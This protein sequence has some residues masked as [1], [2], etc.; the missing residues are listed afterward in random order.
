MK[1]RLF[2]VALVLCGVCFVFYWFVTPEGPHALLYSGFGAL[3]V[4]LTAGFFL[5][6][7]VI[8]WRKGK[9]YKGAD[10][11]C[12]PAECKEEQRELRH[13]AV[14]FLLMAVFTAR[15]AVQQVS[16][17][18]LDFSQG[19]RQGILTNAYAYTHIRIRGFPHYK[20]FGMA[21]QEPVEFSVGRET[22]TKVRSGKKEEYCIT[23]YEHTGSLVKI[24]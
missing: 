16:L 6:A 4:C 21:D 11:S 13:I 10:P 22:Y 5:L 3:L 12:R 1:E 14:C 18:A 24:E 15:V 9:R 17:V 7:A 23:Y 2:G 19:S 8:T 20:V